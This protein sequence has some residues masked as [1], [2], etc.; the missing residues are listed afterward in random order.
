[1]SQNI[2]MVFCAANGSMQTLEIS[3][4]IIMSDSLISFHP[5]ME[6][7]SKY[8]PVSIRFLSKALTCWVVCCHL[9]RISVKFRSIYCMS[10]SSMNFRSSEADL[11]FKVWADTFAL[12]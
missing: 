12:S 9:P 7:P 2:L 6:E 8:A 5:A 11:N 3:G 1:M 4:F 10:C